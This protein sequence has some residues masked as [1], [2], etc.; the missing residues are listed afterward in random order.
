MQA[1]GGALVPPT[2]TGPWNPPP[3]FTT[4]TTGVVD[5]DT[6]EGCV[7]TSDKWYCPAD[8]D[9]PSHGRHGKHR[10]YYHGR[11]YRPGQLIED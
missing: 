4:F 2:R 11:Y 9:D 1:V 6:N 7:W 8:C 5:M 10:V 3:I